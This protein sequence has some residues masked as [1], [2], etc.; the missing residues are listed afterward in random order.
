MKKIKIINSVL[1][2]LFAF[3]LC[4]SSVS[5]KA[6]TGIGNVK[7]TPLKELLNDSPYMK[8]ICQNLK[9]KREF[10]NECKECKYFFLCWGGCSAHGLLAYKNILGKSP[11]S[12][13][14]YENKL[15]KKFKE[16]LLNFYFIEPDPDDILEYEQKEG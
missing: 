16:T 2:M 14:F 10:N 3:V 1:I 15:Y 11:L 13:Y 4:L 6:A 8:H 12:C 5:V 7:Q 9:D